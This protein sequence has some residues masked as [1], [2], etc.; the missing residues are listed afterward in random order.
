MQGGW[1]VKANQPS[2]PD[3]IDLHSSLVKNNF[4]GVIWNINLINIS[5]MAVISASSSSLSSGKISNGFKRTS[6]IITQHWTPVSMAVPVW[7]PG[8]SSTIRVPAVRP[9]Q[10]DWAVLHPR[11]TQLVGTVPEHSLTL[12]MNDQTWS[13]TMMMAFLPFYGC[14]HAI[15]IQNYSQ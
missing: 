1:K 14:I 10:P 3:L 11:W 6:T 9:V 5:V 15:N 8:W 12:M 4:N 13:W 2:I 7:H